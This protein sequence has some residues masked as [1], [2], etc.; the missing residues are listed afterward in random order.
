MAEGHSVDIPMPEPFNFTK[1][2]GWK[3]W[4]ETFELWMSVTNRQ[5]HEEG[6]KINTLLYAMSRTGDSTR[7]FQ[8]FTDLTGEQR[9]QYKSVFDRFTRH[10]KGSRTKLACR[11]ELNNRV[12]KSD[13]TIDEFVADLYALSLEEDCGY[14]AL[15]EE[16]IRDRI[17]VGV[18][19]QDLSDRLQLKGDDL[20]L[21]DTVKI[22]RQSEAVT[23]QRKLLRCKPSEIEAVDRSKGK[24]V[25]QA[26]A[27]P[28]EQ[29]PH[30]ESRNKCGRCG[31]TPSHPWSRCPAKEVKCH[32]CRRIGHFKVACR[33]GRVLEVDEYG[34]GDSESEIEDAFLGSVSVS[35]DSVKSTGWFVD[36]LMAPGTKTKWKIDTGADVSC[37][38]EDRYNPK[39][40]KIEPAD[41]KLYGAGGSKPMEVK[42]MVRTKLRF[43]EKESTEVVYLVKNLRRPLL[44]VPAIENLQVLNTVVDKSSVRAVEIT[45]ERENH[46]QKP[47]PPKQK[48]NPDEIGPLTKEKVKQLFPELFNGLGKL[49]GEYT[50]KLKEG[51]VPFSLSTPRRIPVPLMDKVK[52][53]LA[54]MEDLG[55]ISRVEEPTEWCA[56]LV[57]VPKQSGEV[58][59]CVDLTKLNDNVLRERHMM[60]SVEHTL[61]Q[62]QSGTVYSKLDANCGF[63]QVVLSPECRHLTTF[64]TP[65]GRFAFNRL[66]YGISS[67]PE[68][69][70]KVMNKILD[71]CVGVKCQMDDVL[72]DGLGTRQHDERALVALQKL[73][74]AGATLNDPKTI[75]GADHLEY[76]GQIVGHTGIQKDP[77]KVRAIAEMPEPKNVKELRSFLATV[78]QLGKF[79]PKLSDRDKPLR[80][81]LSK[82][83]AWVWGEAQQKA[84]DD[85]KQELQSDRVLALYDYQKET[86]VSADASSFGLGAVLLQK[87]G[88]GST[89]PVAYAS[90]SLSNVECRY[91]QIEKEA[92]ATT[93]A[94]EKFCDYLVGIEFKVLTDHK[95]LVPLFTTKLVDELP[96]RIQ[97]FRMRL[98]RF[99]FTVQW[100]PGKDLTTADT[101]SRAPLKDVPT[102]QEE[103]LLAD[104]KVF[105]EMVMENLPLSDQRLTQIKA[106]LQKDEVA[107]T[108]MEYCIHGWPD[109]SLLQGEVRKYWQWSGELTVVDGLLMKG[110]RLVIPSSLR[111]EILI[112]LH[113]GHQGITK[114]RERAKQSVWWPGL[115][116]QIEQM[117]QNCGHCIRNSGEK[118]EPLKGRPFPDRPWAV[119]ASDL[120]EL[121]GKKYLLVTD[122][123]SRYPELKQLTS[124]KSKVVIEKLKGLF[125]RHGIPDELD[126]DNGPQYDSVEFREFSKQYGFKHVTSSPGYPTSNGQAEN[127]VK[128]VKNLLRDAKDPYL[129]LLAYRVTPLQNGYSPAELLMGRKL[130]TTVPIHPRQLVPKIPD[131]KLLRQCEEDYRL[132]MAENYN[133]R[134]KAK[135]QD[136]LQCGNLAY[137]PDMKLDG[138]IVESAG[139]PRSYLIRTPKGV[140]RR[141]RKHLRKYPQNVS[142]KSNGRYGVLRNSH[143]NYVEIESDGLG[144]EPVPQ[145]ITQD[146]LEY[147]G[148]GPGSPPTSP[149]RMN[150]TQESVR[151]DSLGPARL[152][153]N[154]VMVLRRSGRESRPPQRL[155]EQL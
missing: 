65:F 44:G 7:L 100:V 52:Q 95:P 57:V 92:L 34:L 2:Q 105:V 153:Q 128:T 134:H 124:T 21:Q 36:L 73:A 39:L 93:W 149:N 27:G 94:C 28:R 5:N 97:R 19:D 24:K 140:I 51:A 120:F 46:K 155:I 152:S 4:A 80:D 116:T 127:C 109:K 114:C 148:G 45:P 131:V 3:Q 16:V 54:R 56:G 87:Q 60:P 78:N 150:Q 47:L 62:I 37:Y 85:L 58:R 135:T 35:V 107:K 129:A 144:G 41:R 64:I 48:F 43:G 110:T 74:D 30:T 68:Y 112:Q 123:Y 10:F 104:T 11:A 13:E 136:E 71:G 86:I 72:I 99:K 55:V 33:S 106:E 83:N 142:V 90:R 50:I 63:W 119:V 23:N 113:G 84:F 31:R 115:S 76:L 88:D 14:G 139:K 49:P 59:L 20:S 91:A 69:F 70:Q 79:V 118:C 61:A 147:Q 32:K 111:P 101:L 117:V 26:R 42:G 132:K 138:T 6:T 25:P 102:K 53:E 38:P 122:Q 130:K 145:E 146:H 17:I 143:P 22:A 125:S 137:V 9:K 103:T 40:G 89:R 81:L 151:E 121:N 66:P 126:S 1:P 141:N 82:K 8:T 98:M 108:I 12:Q 15:R 133:R 67:A 96:V 75:I 154:P 77:E 29:N 18:R